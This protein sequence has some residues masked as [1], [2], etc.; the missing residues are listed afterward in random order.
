M[1]LEALIDVQRYVRLGTKAA[2]CPVHVT[3]IFVRSANVSK[4]TM[5]AGAK[6]CP[7][8]GVYHSA[9]QRHKSVSDYFTSEQILPFGSARQ[10]CHHQS[11]RPHASY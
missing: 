6:E 8:C 2:E 9:L 3:T 7:V 4:E 11:Q 1:Q 10:Y 5:V